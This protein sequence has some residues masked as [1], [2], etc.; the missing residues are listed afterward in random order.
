MERT[1]QMEFKNLLQILAQNTI[2]IKGQL[3][4]IKDVN[5]LLFVRPSERSNIIATCHCAIGHSGIKN[6]VEK[7]KE[8]YYWESIHL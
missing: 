5:K 1:P 6:N 2:T 4:K 7:N 8:D 3:F